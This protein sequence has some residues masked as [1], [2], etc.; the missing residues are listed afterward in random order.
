MTIEVVPLG[1]CRRQNR[2]QTFRQLDASQGAMTAAVAATGC[3]VASPLVADEDDLHAEE[4]ESCRLNEAGPTETTGEF[5]FEQQEQAL[6]A[7]RT[8]QM[9]SKRQHQVGY[10]HDLNEREERGEKES[11]RGLPDSFQVNR[12]RTREKVARD[13]DVH[14]ASAA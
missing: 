3:S 6:E 4:M 13:R 11:S 10:E 9:M 8:V 14:K 7:Q 12:F 1:R 2:L 5:G